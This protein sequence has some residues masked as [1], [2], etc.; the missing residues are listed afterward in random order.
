MELVVLYL[1][2][3]VKE[4]EVEAVVEEDLLKVLQL[5]DH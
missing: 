3:L 4:V 2:D 5:E 1:L